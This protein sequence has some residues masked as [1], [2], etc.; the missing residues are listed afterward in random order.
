MGKCRRD[1]SAT[2]KPTFP[3][4]GVKL[5][6]VRWLIRAGL[7]YPNYFPDANDTI[8]TLAMIET[9]QAVENLDG[10]LATPHLTGVYVGPGDLAVSMGKPPALDHTDPEMVEVI[11]GIL[12][13]VKDAGLKCGMHCLNPPFMVDA[14]K[15]GFDFVTL[16]SDVRIFT[17]GQSDAVGAFRKAGGGDR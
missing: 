17:A 12:K 5:E 16:A 13:K 10:I 3:T 6:S 4:P 2:V 9:V 1:F 8:V 7:V 15:Q 11:D 14:V